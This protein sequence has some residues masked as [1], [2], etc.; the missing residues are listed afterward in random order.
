MLQRFESAPKP[1]SVRLLN[2]VLRDLVRGGATRRHDWALAFR[3]CYTRAD[4]Q[5]EAA[6]RGL[7]RRS[8][9]EQR[10]EH[11]CSFACQLV[12]GID[13]LRVE[14]ADPINVG[15]R[16]GLRPCKVRHVSR[17]ETK[18]AGLQLMECRT[19]EPPAHP[20]PP[21][22]LHDND[23]LVHRVNVWQHDV[24]GVVVNTHRE[25]LSRRPRVAPHILDPLSRRELVQRN[26]AGTSVLVRRLAVSGPDPQRY[27]HRYGN[28]SLEHV[29]SRSSVKAG[30][31]N[32]HF[33]WESPRSDIARFTGSTLMN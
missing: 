10:G 9:L 25:Q 5:R 22:A 16:F 33:T 27:Q 1:L 4:I 13:Q 21:V 19:V 29:S 18:R 23:I 14:R 12:G 26:D 31:I 3:S 15:D 6:G 28:R 8:G 20:E 32:L 2:P 7:G 11:E 24:A 17:T 30:T